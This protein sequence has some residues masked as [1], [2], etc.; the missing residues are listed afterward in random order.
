MNGIISFKN[1]IKK[2]FNSLGFDV[3][4]I[5][6]SP[7]KTLLGLRNLPIRTIIDVGANTGQF[8][9]YILTLFQDAHLFCFEPLPEAFEK[10][11]RWSKD[12]RKVMV[13]NFALGEKENTLEMFKH[14]DHSSSSSF[15]K[16]TKICEKI[17]SLTKKQNTIPVKVTTL[18]SLLRSLQS[19]LI[20]EILIKLD[21][22]GYEDRVIRGGIETFNIAKACILEV[23]LN[24]LY[25]NQSTFKDILFLLHDLGFSYIG[26]S[27][28]AYADDGH[29]IFVDSIF[30]KNH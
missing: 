2:A 8:A 4:R 11:S 24:H 26:N 22:Q 29:V 12:N 5:K 20:P 3:I 13:F 10:L 17:Y 9:R 15:L 28:Q 6:N 21:V 14:I 1:L 18:D 23:C 25:E 30:V 27:E 16:T 7:M 19:P